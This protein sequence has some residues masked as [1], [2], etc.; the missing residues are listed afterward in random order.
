MVDY[1]VGNDH[2]ADRAITLIAQTHSAA[3]ARYDIVA[4]NEAGVLHITGDAYFNDP[5]NG[6]KESKDPKSIVFLTTSN[7]NVTLTMKFANDEFTTTLNRL[8][9]HTLKYYNILIV[10][11]KRTTK[12][13]TESPELYGK[14]YLWI[15]ITDPLTNVVLKS[16]Y[17]NG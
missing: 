16:G 9:N 12:K 13:N 5:D 1:I 15:Q 3:L 8:V 11:S 10:V 4:D 14:N 6:F 2:I 7:L 17:Y